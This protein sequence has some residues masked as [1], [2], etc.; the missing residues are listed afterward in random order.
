MNKKYLIVWNCKYLQEDHSCNKLIDKKNK[1]PLSSPIDGFNYKGDVNLKCNVFEAG[2]LFDPGIKFADY[3]D[4]LCL[5]FSGKI[6]ETIRKQIPLHKYLFILIEGS[7]ENPTVIL[8]FSNEDENVFYEIQKE[9]TLELYRYDLPPSTYTLVDSAASQSVIYSYLVQKDPVLFSRRAQQFLQTPH[10]LTSLLSQVMIL[11]S[12]EHINFISILKVLA[13][14]FRK[15]LEPHIKKIKKD[16][17]SL[18]SKYYG[19]RISFLDGGMSRIVSLPGTEPMGIRVGIYTVI[20]GEV[21]LSKREEWVINPFVIGD[22]ISDKR[23][24]TDNEGRPDIKRLQEAARYILEPLAGY[25]YIKTCHIKPTV[26]FLHGPLQNSYAT[27][28]EDSPYFIPSVNTDFLSKYGIE[29]SEVIKIIEHIPESH[30]REVM[31]NGCISIYAYIMKK[32]FNCSVPIAGV[33]ERS[34]SDV[35]IK[36]ILNMIEYKN[37]IPK[38]TRISIWEYLKKYEIGDELLFGCIL[39]EGEYI[40]P[41]E[42]IKNQRHRAHDKWKLVMDQFP[43]PIS[44]MIK[45]S[46]NNFPFRVELNGVR[47]HAVIDDVISLLYHTSLLLPNYSFPVGIDIADKYA[48]IPD[49][50]SKGIS[51]RLAASILKK[52]LEIGDDRMLRQVRQLLA[53]SPRDFFFRPKI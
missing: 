15:Y 6:L 13:D 43:A 48:K 44:T 38:S 25:H 11:E 4:F 8:R 40:E 36:G 24:I 51:E 35:F 12:K 31:W 10:I 53:L 17:N 18:W 29:K 49:W 14:H 46:P 5:D 34:R 26:M 21:D 37:I 39:D 20:P 16:H 19:E 1:L 28:D 50:L 30:N 3:K 42:V 9:S 2:Q 22:V 52:V 23:Y 45:C 47:D 41:F 33:V 7:P 32:I 27:Y